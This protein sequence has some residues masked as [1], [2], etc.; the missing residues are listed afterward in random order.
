MKTWDKVAIVG[1]GLIG[2]S[3]GLGLLQRQLARVV[4]GIGRRPESLREAEQQ[5]AV[6][7]STCDLA[8]GLAEADLVVVC[9][10]VGRIADDVVQAATLGPTGSLI[11]DAGSTK[12]EIVAQVEAAARDNP[13]WQ[14]GVRFLGSHPLAG[15]EKKGPLHARADLFEG[16]VAVVTPTAQTSDRDRRLLEDF[17]TGLGARVVEMSPEEHDK[18]LAA[19]SHLPH[20]VASA[21][22]AT[23]P[24]EY[25]TLTAGGWLDTTRIAAGDPDL[26]RQI[27]LSNRANVVEWLERLER[28]LADFKQS[29]AAG[30]GEELHQ[31]LTEA[32]RIRDAVG[33]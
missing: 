7:S 18:R 19:T 23:T 3:I 26:W 22:A 30:R 33:S 10:P 28:K 11:T 21:I 6:T 2:G 25:V 12:A 8:A 16:R 14:S 9:T 24:E 1:V 32:K 29:L 20:L 31:L 15:N 13:A 5:G 17:W 4:V 27:L